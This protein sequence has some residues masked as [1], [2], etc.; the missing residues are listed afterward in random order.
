M[1][2]NTRIGILLIT[3]FITGTLSF[4]SFN[5]KASDY[6]TQS[7]PGWEAD[8]G[9]WHYYKDG[10]AVTGWQSLNGSWFYFKPNGYMAIGWETID[11]KDYYFSYEGKMMTNYQTTEGYWVDAH[12]VRVPKPKDMN[13]YVIGK[14]SDE[15][16]F[17][18]NGITYIPLKD[19]A[20]SMGWPWQ[21][22]SNNFEKL[23]R[24]QM[25]EK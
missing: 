24:E 22:N 3:L 9:G 6:D 8:T 1:S 21:I 19:I 4:S 10:I 16:P 7:M 23:M 12:G 2:K 20:E 25:Y 13:L 18:M 11:G 17:V 14:L 5:V 15:E